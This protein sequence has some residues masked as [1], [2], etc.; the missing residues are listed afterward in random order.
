[1]FEETHTDILKSERA[2]IGVLLGEE[3]LKVG[4]V[5][6]GSCRRIRDNEFH[7]VALTK[8]TLASW[9]IG[10]GGEVS[11]SAFWSRESGCV[12]SE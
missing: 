11:V 10:A 9:A 4:I 7:K 8:N 3:A 12:V 1:L 2:R 6:V 5:G